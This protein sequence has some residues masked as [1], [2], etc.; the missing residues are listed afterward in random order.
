[1]P[2]YLKD[3]PAVGP[4]G[5]YTGKTYGDYEDTAMQFTRAM[6]EV[7]RE[8]DADHH[9][10]AFPKCDLHVN[11]DTFSDPRQR[12]LLDF[13][14]QIAGENGTPYFI[15]DRDEVTLSA[16][17]RLRTTIQDKYMIEHPESMRFC[18]FQN[19]TINLPQAALRAG[20]GNYDGL[21]QEI[22]DAMDLA[23]KAHLQKKTFIGKLM[24]SPEM[25]LWEIGKIAADGRPYVDLEKVTYIIGVIGLNECVQHLTGHELHEDDET[26][27][28][29]LRIIS[30]MYLAV[31]EYNKEFGLKFSL[32]ESP[33]E[34]ASRRLAKVD[35][36]HFPEAAE[37]VKGDLE[38]DEFYYTNSIHLRADS[39]VDLVT[40][41]RKQAKFHTLIESG[42][43]IHAFVGEERPSPESIFNLVEKTF[44]NTNA[45][46]LTI[47]PEFT[48]CNSCNRM[49]IGLLNKCPDC[50]DEN[51]Y[52]ITRI[53][54][55]FSRINNWNKSKLGELKDRHRGDYCVSSG[56][57]AVEEENA[58]VLV[59]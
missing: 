23:L 1:V 8:G 27:K 10:F 55:Y 56:K 49:N 14:C 47:S 30:E 21:I 39:P 42:A 17:C 51:V 26:F 12:E 46:Q 24:A 3:I 29:G 37:L 18:G 20:K 32:E 13:A 57:A 16:C 50:H 38:R 45:A 22:K 4:G 48:V 9:V 19:V 36:R 53:V 43:I 54:G 5:E 59:E 6:L 34:S 52:Q 35:V 44:R 7:W 33:A 25:P 31:K 2:R 41:I 40:R 58:G 28:L 11:D 15:F